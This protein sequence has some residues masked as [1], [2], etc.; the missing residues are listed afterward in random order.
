[1]SKTKEQSAIDVIYSLVEK[2]DL[3]DKKI[4]MID[5][6]V[7]HLNNKVSK[8]KTFSGPTTSIEPRPVP[9]PSAATPNHPKKIEV[10]KL[11]LGSIKVFGYI[12][13]KNRVPITDVIINICNNNSEVVKSEGSNRDGYWEVRL[14]KGRYGVEYSH[15]R[16]KSVNKTIILEKDIS[17]Y[18][19]K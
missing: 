7:K 9:Q 5:T 10:D 13:D 1:M 17:S 19:V 15:S 16:F 14:P 6:N 3:L 2:V 4:D 12:V 11:V 18:E 8:L